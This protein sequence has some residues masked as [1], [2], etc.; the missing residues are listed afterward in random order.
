MRQETP[1][2]LYVHLPFCA[3]RCS[4]CDFLSGF[5]PA[6]IP[7]Y[8]D[9]VLREAELALDSSSIW[10]QT[11]YDTIYLGGGTPSWLGASHL[12]KL[13]EGLRLRLPFH[14]NCEWT[15]ECNPSDIEVELLDALGRA[16]A[17]RISLGVQSFVD[18]ELRY[19]GR[20]HDGSTA[21]VALGR[22]RDHRN[23]FLISLDLMHDLPDQTLNNLNRSIETALSFHPEHLSCYA[24]TLIPGTPL[25]KRVAARYLFK[26]KGEKTNTQKDL[27]SS[28]VHYLHVETKLQ[29]AGFEH[30]EVSNYARANMRSRHNQKYWNRTRVLALGCGPAGTGI[31]PVPFGPC[32][33]GP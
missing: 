13:I 22:I 30:Y 2:G 4:Y 1:A 11:S 21:R 5:D 12:V 19:L 20:R 23:G 31:G 9:A 8:I 17:N 16:G 25:A 26:S 3:S 10:N 33:G 6:T 24:L 27:D 15:V 14:D 32:S 18:R 7:T 28:L 29:E